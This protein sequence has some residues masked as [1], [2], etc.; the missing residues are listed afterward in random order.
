MN[1]SANARP[2]RIRRAFGSSTCATQSAASRA[3]TPVLD[4]PRGQTDDPSRF[5]AVDVP[6]LVEQRPDALPAVLVVQQVVAFG[7]HRGVPRFDRDRIGDR[8]LEKAIEARCVDDLVGRRAGDVR[9]GRRS[10]RRRTCRGALPVG[11]SESLRSSLVR[12]GGSRRAAPPRACRGASA[13]EAVRAMVDLPAPGHPAMPMIR[14]PSAT[15]AFWRCILVAPRDAT[16]N[17]R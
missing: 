8:L 3:G 11:A 14:R 9:A 1:R 5:V 7:D 17:R 10:R 12:R 15:P 4:V 13:D 2:A 6:A 16:R